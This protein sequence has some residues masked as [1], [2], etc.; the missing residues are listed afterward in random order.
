M[1]GVL[2]EL[3]RRGTDKGIRLELPVAGDRSAACLDA[4][5]WMDLLN[6]QFMFRRFEP[7][8][9][10]DDSQAEKYSRLLLIFG[11][12][13]ATDYP[14]IMGCEG[15]EVNIDRPAQPVAGEA[16]ATLPAGR[17]MTYGE[18]LALRFAAAGGEP[19]AGPVPEPRAPGDVDTAP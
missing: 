2:R 10:L 17:C 4:A 5:F 18:R 1:P 7:S 16:D 12:L 11:I 3:R 6:R 15:A 13:R 9:F 19:V 8:V 14:L